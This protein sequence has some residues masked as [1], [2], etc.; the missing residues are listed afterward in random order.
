MKVL[1]YKNEN[2][3]YMY[4]VKFIFLPENKNLKIF[5]KSKL[6]KNK[7]QLEIGRTLSY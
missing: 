4:L 7:Y 1:V 6:K 5:N 3:E 2:D